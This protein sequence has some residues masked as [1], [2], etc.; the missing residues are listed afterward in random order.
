VP[1]EDVVQEQE[2]YCLSNMG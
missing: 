1:Q 2:A